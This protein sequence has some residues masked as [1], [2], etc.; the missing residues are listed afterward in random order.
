MRRHKKLPPD[1]YLMADSFNFFYCL[2]DGEQFKGAAPL[3]MADVI[4]KCLPYVVVALP[5]ATAQT[6]NKKIYTLFLTNPFTD[7]K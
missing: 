6:I 4:C 5:N 1:L 3:H 7:D 2:L